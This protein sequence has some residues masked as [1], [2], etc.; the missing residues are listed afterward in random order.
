MS[1]AIQRGAS[2][3][4]ALA[5]NVLQSGSIEHCELSTTAT[6]ELHRLKLVRAL[7]QCGAVH[8]KQQREVLVGQGELI[9]VDTVMDAQKPT[10]AALFHA[11]VGVAGGQLDDDGE[12]CLCVTPDDLAEPAKFG[13]DASEVADRQLLRV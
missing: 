4:V 8:G 2:D 1:H 13:Q 7:A 3:R 12:R 6:D 5:G 10:C 11:V 9:A